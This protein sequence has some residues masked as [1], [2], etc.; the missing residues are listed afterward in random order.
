M[1]SKDTA[2][3]VRH[4]SLTPGPRNR[5]PARGSGGYAGR[6]GRVVT[7]RWRNP[8]AQLADGHSANSLRRALSDIAMIAGCFSFLSS[9]IA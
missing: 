2:V 8:A 4:E 7:K 3:A 9:E 5:L 6:T 1:E